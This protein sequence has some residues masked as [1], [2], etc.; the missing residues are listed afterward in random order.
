[1]GK[2]KIVTPK[3]AAA[4]I[5]EGA[6]IMVGGFMGVGNPHKV[7]EE[8]HKL[9][10]GNLTLI[11]NDASKPAGPEGE[12]DWGVAKLISS[13]QVTK[14]IATHVGLNPEVGK[15]MN[16]GTL[17]VTLIPQGSFVEMIRAAGAGL[18]GVLTPTGFGTIIEEAWH[19]DR[20][21]EVEGRRYLLEK[22]LR[23]DF[24]L[25]CGYK[26]DKMGNVW[27]KGTQ[28]TF[29][30]MMATAATT[31]VAEAVN[32]VEPGEIAPEDVITSRILVDYIASE[33]A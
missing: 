17:D 20:V 26:V 18:G 30:E 12:V 16:E 6:S 5:P 15:R 9:G 4:L 28:R 8:L 21:I 3:D 14:I 29:S 33:E 23:A 24:A 1:M 32:L 27:Y 31:V 13:G 11:C 25:V 10:T 19:V 7:I 22:P 2:A